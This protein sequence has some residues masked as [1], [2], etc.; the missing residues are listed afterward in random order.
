MRLWIV[1]GVL[2]TI[3]LGA[4][5]SLRL[6]ERISVLWG[7]CD[8]VGADLIRSCLEVAAASST[9]ER[10]LRLVFWAL[11]SVAGVLAMPLIAALVW[12]TLRAFFWVRRGF[13]SPIG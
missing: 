1:A 8:R 3:G 6:F 5:Q 9:Q 13:T 2:W 4:Y 10:N 11:G 7:Q 12:T